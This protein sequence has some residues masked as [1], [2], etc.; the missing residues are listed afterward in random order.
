MLGPRMGIF[1]ENSTHPISI[2]ECLDIEK[3]KIPD[4]LL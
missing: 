3:G 2:V 4:K 1:Y